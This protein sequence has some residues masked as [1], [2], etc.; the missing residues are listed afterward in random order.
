[1]NAAAAFL[2]EHLESKALG[3]ARIA[4]RF[5]DNLGTD[6]GG[7]AKREGDGGEGFFHDYWVAGSGPALVRRTE[8]DGY[9]TGTF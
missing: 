6:A 3:Q 8:C 1:M 4:Q 9:L 2:P 7:I 5:R